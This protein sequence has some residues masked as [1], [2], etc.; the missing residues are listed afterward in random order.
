MHRLSVQ[1]PFLRY[2]GRLRSGV[3]FGKF[4]RNLSSG[5]KL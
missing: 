1:Y 3:S 4:C 5:M 2:E